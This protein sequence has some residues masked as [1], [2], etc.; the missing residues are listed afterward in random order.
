MELA[1]KLISIPS[2][3]ADNGNEEAISDYIYGYLKQFGYFQVKKQKVEDGRFNII[4]T[5]G[6]PEKLAFFCH[7]DTLSSSPK[8]KSNPFKPVVKKGKLYGLGA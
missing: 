5:D 1:A 3:V 2:Y 6:Y 7:M 4:A 8:W